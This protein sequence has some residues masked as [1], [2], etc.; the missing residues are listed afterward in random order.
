MKIFGN[1]AVFV[2]LYLL[3]MLPTYFLPY[4]GSNSALIGTLGQI[5]AA[6]GD[7]NPLMGINPAFWPH[8]ISLIVLVMASWFRGGVVDKKW[9]I[10]F[11]ILAA[12]FDLLPVL[13][14]IPL[15]P[16]VMHILTIAFGVAST[17]SVVVSETQKNT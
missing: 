16:T 1:T 17:N 11:P 15:I 5:G 8:L 2:V 4:F 14:S 9:L 12:V 13:N 3:F 6:A 10:T 7:V